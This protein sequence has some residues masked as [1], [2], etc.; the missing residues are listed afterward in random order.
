M[1]IGNDGSQSV[2]AYVES[3]L[4]L[5]DLENHLVQHLDSLEPGLTLLGRQVDT[6]VGRIAILAQAS[7]GEKVVIE[8]EVGEAKEA[9]IGQ[10]TKYMGWY[11]RA[12][13]TP[14]RAVLVAASFEQPLRYAAA[15][16]PGLRLA[17]YRMQLTF[18][19]VEG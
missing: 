19:D 17:S 18:E 5:R 15:A 1:Q 7:S 6:E 12:D 9:A 10:I 16:V 11:A 4:S 8:L 14:P 2:A 13:G 3:T